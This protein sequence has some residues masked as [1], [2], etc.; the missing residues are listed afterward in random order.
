M[1]LK[2]LPPIL[3]KT[4]VHFLKGSI[5]QS[6][7]AIDAYCQLYSLFAKLSRMFPNLKKAIDQEVDKFYASDKNRHKKTAGDLGEFMIK[8]ALSSDGFTNIEIV[9]L[10]FKEYLARQISWACKADRDLSRRAQCPDLV[11]KF[12]VAAQVSNQFFLVQLATSQLLLKKGMKAELDENYGF[13]SSAKM[14]DFREKIVWIQKKCKQGLETLCPRNWIGF[15][16][17]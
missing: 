12:M 2:V 8:L 1:V 4:I 5:H 14:N 15:Y 13:L 9:K 7:V 16:H 6:L 10:L 3:V 17:S 11:K